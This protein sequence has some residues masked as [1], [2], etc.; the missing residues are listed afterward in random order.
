MA[1]YKP[2]RNIRGTQISYSKFQFFWE[3]MGNETQIYYLWVYKEDEQNMPQMFKYGSC[4]EK[5]MEV[6]FQYSTLSLAEIQKVRFLIFASDSPIAPDP[7]ELVRMCQNPA[8]ICEVCCGTGNVQWS[9]MRDETGMKL[10]IQSD[11]KIPEGFL[12]FEYPYG[13]QTFQYEIPGEIPCGV[14]EY[15]NIILPELYVEPQLKSLVNNLYIQ[16]M[17]K[18]MSPAS[19]EKESLFDR[20]IN[21]F[22]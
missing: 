15:R 6:N 7:K 18:K 9:W 22:R 16:K 8:F 3:D 10:L 13:N 19:A 2:L 1:C 20:L 17:E 14:T 12:Y 21:V 11:K 4:V 5:R